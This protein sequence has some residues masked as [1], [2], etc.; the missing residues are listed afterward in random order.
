MR[1]RSQGRGTRLLGE[2]GSARE[3]Y[4]NSC[5]KVALANSGHSYQTPAHRSKEGGCRALQFRPVVRV[6]YQTTRASRDGWGSRTG[7]K[8]P[9]F[10]EVA[11]R[12][13]R[14]RCAGAHVLRSLERANKTASATMDGIHAAIIPKRNHW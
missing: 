13:S 4:Q 14:D 8:G 10:A 1:S 7:P 5:A 9:A 2:A 3:G 6:W 12:R 11:D